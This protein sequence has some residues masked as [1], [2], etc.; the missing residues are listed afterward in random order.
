MRRRGGPEQTPQP[1][2]PNLLREHPRS[3]QDDALGLLDGQRLSGADPD[4]A[5]FVLS[6]RRHQRGHHLPGGS[7]GVDTEVNGHQRPS[8]PA[9]PLHEVREVEQPAR[10]PVPTRRRPAPGPPF[11]TARRAAS[12][13]AR[14]VMD[15]PEMPASSC[16][17]TN[18]QP[19]RSASASMVARWAARPAPHG[20]DSRVLPRAQSE[21]SSQLCARLWATS[22]LRLVMFHS[23]ERSAAV[24]GDQNP[25]LSVATPRHPPSPLLERRSPGRGHGNGQDFA[26]CGGV[27]ASPALG[28]GYLI[29]GKAVRDGRQ[30]LSGLALGHHPGHDLVDDEPG[31]A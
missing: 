21:Y 31:A 17:A 16:T 18:C 2:G 6:E 10:E 3:G 4:D 12:S 25:R 27:P 11:S 19:R 9:A 23:D 7:C 15:L 8:L 14:P 24:M 29:G 28:C 13:P 5:S 26:N 22:T 30:C 20:P 1:S